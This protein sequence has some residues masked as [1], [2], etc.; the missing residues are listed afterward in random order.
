MRVKGRPLRRFGQRGLVA[1]F[2][3]DFA[4]TGHVNAQQVPDTAFVPPIEAPEYRDG[5]RPPEPP[6]RT[7]PPALAQRPSP[8][9]GHAAFLHAVYDDDRDPYPRRRRP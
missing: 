8:V 2:W 9:I 3:F 6:L 5:A 1:T 7:E 4:S